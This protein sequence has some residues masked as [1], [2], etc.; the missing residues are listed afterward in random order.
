MIFI[1]DND[2]AERD[3]LRLLLETS[4]HAA[5]DFP[6]AEAFPRQQRFYRARLSCPQL[7]EDAVALLG[8]RNEGLRVT[9]HTSPGLAQVVVDRVEIQQVLINL[10]RN[11]VE[12]CATLSK[13][14]RRP[15]R[16]EPDLSAIPTDGRSVQIN[17]KDTGPGHSQNVAERL[18]QPF[19]STKASGMGVGLSICRTIIL[20]NG[21]RIWTE[22][23][24]DG[25]TISSFTLPQTLPG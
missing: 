17:V 25:G 18:F 9:T 22:P 2:P 12:A 24:A 14:W 3:S 15:G 16:R 1:V 19:V 6:S 8:M 20:R 10:V 7:F 21:G 11:A 4:G 23:N 5:E 13:R